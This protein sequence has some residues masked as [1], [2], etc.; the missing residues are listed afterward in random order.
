MSVGELS[1]QWQG[2]QRQV[3]DWLTEAGGGARGEI[4]IQSTRGPIFKKNV[5]LNLIICFQNANIQ[6][7]I[8][9]NTISMTQ[10]RQCPADAS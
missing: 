6:C 10:R 4:K 7:H 1:S 3:R 8:I 2:L 9:K 5:L